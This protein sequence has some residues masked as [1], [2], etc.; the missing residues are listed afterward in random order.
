GAVTAWNHL[1]RLHDDSRAVGCS[2]EGRQAKDRRM[3]AR[4]VD[5]KLVTP[6]IGKAEAQ[7]R[8]ILV[9]RRDDDVRGPGVQRQG[10]G[11]RL[12]RVQRADPN[13]DRLALRPWIERLGRATELRADLPHPSITLSASD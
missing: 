4:V 11:V 12:P 2:L 8:A 6:Q 10:H 9:A 7:P 13:R 3:V 1:A 5:R